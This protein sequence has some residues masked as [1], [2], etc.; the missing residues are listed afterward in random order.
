M[1]VD[2]QNWINL[3]GEKTIDSGGY[4]GDLMTVARAH[5]K[6]AIDNQQITQ[7]Q[8]GE[9]YTAMIP[10]AFQTAYSFSI[11]QEKIRLSKV[12]STLG[13]A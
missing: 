5:I 8:A 7:E 13:K 6:N 4:A 2:S 12:P 3:V 1:A 9:I 11:E 10:S